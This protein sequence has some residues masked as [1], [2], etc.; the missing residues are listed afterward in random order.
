MA[1][2][3]RETEVVA[4]SRPAPPKP[5]TGET[6]LTSVIPGRAAMVIK[7]R[8]GASGQE[9]RERIRIA[10]TQA[11]KDIT[12][13]L[14]RFYAS[15]VARFELDQ[16]K[17]RTAAELEAYETAGA[18]IRRRFEIY[19]EQREPV[20]TQLTLLAG[21]PDPN[22]TSR[23]PD[24]PLPPALQKR[25]DEAKELR[26]RLVEIDRE[27][28][29]DVD[30]IL[31]SVQDVIAAQIA[32]LRLRVEQFKEELDRRAAE[33]A[34]A[35]VRETAKELGLELIEPKNVT[36]PGT[37]AKSVTIAG[38]PP[39]RPAPDVPSTGILS[40]KADRERLLKHE[41]EVW[42]GLNRYTLDKG[43][44]DVTGEFLKWREKFEVGR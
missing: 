19:A 25:F 3:L 40:G 15:E 4:L 36:L 16:S 44:K 27:F 7:D 10:Q 22:S 35:Q 34:N 21:F 17:A 26:E 6:A 2:V 5:P 39:F 11:L 1:R 12:S 24:N 14:R 33:E 37:A 42:L 29:N 41:L 20:Y 32:A 31:S 18:R 9:I 13:R 28:R 30:Q 38:G 43:A 8:P 23:P